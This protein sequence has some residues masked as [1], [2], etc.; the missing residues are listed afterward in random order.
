MIIIITV[1][2]LKVIAITGSFYGIRID[3]SIEMPRTIL[4]ALIDASTPSL[5][6]TE[7]SSSRPTGS[8]RMLDYISDF[9]GGIK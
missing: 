4:T 8:S 1:P 6:R 2:S 5:K 7:V 3:F 9:V